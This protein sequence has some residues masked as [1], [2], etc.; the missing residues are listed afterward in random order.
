MHSALYA[1]ARCPSVRPCAYLSACMTVCLS[2][3]I[4]YWNGWT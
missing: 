3:V 2:H 4:L 1:I